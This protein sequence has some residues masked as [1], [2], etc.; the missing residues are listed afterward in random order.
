MSG[1]QEPY[2]TVFESFP[3]DRGVLGMESGRWDTMSS[4]NAGMV[5]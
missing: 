4:A 1:T 5:D 3:V 2:M